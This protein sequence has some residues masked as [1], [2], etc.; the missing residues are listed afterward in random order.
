MTL[1]FN[2]W[3]TV[4]MEGI[5]TAGIYNGFAGDSATE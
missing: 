2:P 5:R 3:S 1:K 4:L